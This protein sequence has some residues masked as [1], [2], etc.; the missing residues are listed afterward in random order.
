[1]ILKT[2]LR[3][4]IVL[5]CLNFT[6]FSQE[7]KL[8][9]SEIMKGNE[10]IGFQ[11]SNAQWSPDNQHIYF[12]WGKDQ[13][14]QTLWY[15]FD[16]LLNE[17]VQLNSLE[18]S[19]IPKNGYLTDINKR[20]IYFKNGTNLFQKSNGKTKLIFSFYKYYR[21]EKIMQNGEI[22][23]YISGQI[24]SFNPE[25]GT[26]IQL[27]KMVPKTK[28][29]KRSQLRKQQNDLFEIIKK[30]ND[31]QLLKE[32]SILPEMT[33]DNSLDWFEIDDNHSSIL[34]Q[35][36]N[37]PKNEMTKYASYVTIDG[38]TESKI[39]RPKVG[40]KNP[41]NELKLVDLKSNIEY[42]ID[43]SKLTGITDSPD[44]FKYY[45]DLKGE[46]NLKEVIYHNHGSSPDG[47]LF[48][49]E[50]KSY[51]N[52]D[53]WICTVDHT[54]KLK[55]IE[56][57]RDTAWIGGP[58]ISGWTSAPGNLGWINDETIFFQ[59]EE[60][61]YSHLYTYQLT[62]NKKT[63]LTE[64]RY[65]VHGAVLSK[66]RDKF[67]ITANHNHPGNR[68][69]YTLDIR[70]KKLTAILT[71]GGNHEVT[72]SPDE[73]K[74]AV[75]YSYINKPW[76]LYLAPL[77][78][79][80]K[81]QQIT[82]SATKEFQA[83]DW[84]EAAVVNLPASDGQMLNARFY[85]PNADKKNGAA[86]IFVHGAGYLQNAHNW[87][88]GYYREYMFHNLLADK[89]Y[90]VMDIDYRAS[91][92][93]GRD[94]RTAIY[95][96]MGGKDL[97]DQLDGREFLIDTYKIDSNRIGI[98][99]GSYGGFITLMALL[100]EPGK[101]RCGA[102]LRSVTDWAHYNHPYT[103]NILNTPELDSI[104][105]SRSSPIYFA[106]NLVDKLIMLHGMEDGNVQYQDVVR[107]SQRFIELG[108]S[109]WDLI[110]Y[111]IEGHGF[112]ESSSWTDEY[113]RILELFDT[114]LLAD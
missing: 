24:V 64:G 26:F 79:N 6:S 45:P 86:I 75:R 32:E 89:G 21:I 33:S 51:D 62:K 46:G 76:E 61:A 73:K 25:Q 22:I 107:L 48:L 19:Q 43:I 10:F 49:V 3:F 35:E 44:Y 105:Y 103:S 70:T 92:G 67:F 83:Y 85:F 27:I 37:Y 23:M 113:R 88:S 74:L 57:Q 63:Q 16:V 90:L 84:R 82:S 5:V 97:S 65:E 30:R 9:L 1:M 91:K 36:T 59:S 110:A 96:Q 106:E 58:G 102:A 42:D 38:Y 12:Q 39:S 40:S 101:F 18:K 66:T 20:K 111:P 60:T 77:S 87:W 94:F 109:N 53:R 71:V 47:K 100:T 28:M 68:E 13:S 14:G 4:F 80:A 108:K 52:K 98:Y 41:Q 2:N 29:D 11:P 95:R 56:H 114:E 93:Y 99:G 54:S 78:E 50:I 81:M 7:N 69:F 15:D 72:I 31:N 104:A 34:Y 17:Y 8:L 112:K 55:E